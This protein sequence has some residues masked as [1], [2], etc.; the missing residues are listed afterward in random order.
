MSVD[1]GVVVSTS[2][3]LVLLPPA[4]ESGSAPPELADE[5]LIWEQF[6]RRS[7]TFFGFP[8]EFIIISSFIIEC[9]WRLQ[10]H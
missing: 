4:L 2:V 5:Q 10:L 6:R 1:G 3:L 8:E 9:S 7:L